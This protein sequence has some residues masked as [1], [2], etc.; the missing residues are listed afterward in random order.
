[1]RTHYVFVIYIGYLLYTIALTIV[2]VNMLARY[3]AYYDIGINASANSLT[4][5]FFITPPFFL[6][7]LIATY[8]IHFIVKRLHGR[9][10]LRVLMGLLSP[11]LVFLMAFFMEVHRTADYPGYKEKDPGEFLAFYFGIELHKATSCHIESSQLA[12]MQIASLH[13]TVEVP[14]EIVLQ[15]ETKEAV[16]LCIAGS[17]GTR[18]PC[19]VRISAIDEIQ[20]DF[21]HWQAVPLHIQGTLYYDTVFTILD[22]GVC[23]QSLKGYI[24]L[25]TRYFRI[26]AS[27]YN[28]Y[29]EPDVTWC[30]PFLQTIRDD[31]ERMNDVEEAYKKV[32]NLNPPPEIWDLKGTYSGWGFL[33]QAYF[34]YQAEAS[35]FTLLEHHQ[36]FLEES[37]FNK[38]IQQTD[39]LKSFPKD[40]SYWTTEQIDLAN[41]T[42]FTV[43]IFPYVHY[44][45]YTPDTGRTQH[46]VT[47]M[48]D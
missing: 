37:E 41:K 7:M 6:G 24:I 11:L 33:A 38:Q 35:Y 28:K 8:G 5:L 16:S 48:R 1:M 44:I 46:F 36:H 18:Y 32:V 34:T 23:L 17:F 26:I 3:W 20:E 4:L 47:G 2:F 19:C 15:E 45:V 43:I 14:E 39:C 40:F 30:V 27:G 42:C 21:H 25:N 22:S 13:L 31:E 12:V 29:G 10:W 9:M